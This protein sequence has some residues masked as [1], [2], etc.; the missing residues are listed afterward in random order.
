MYCSTE[1]FTISLFVPCRL[2]YLVVLLS[3]FDTF[4][5]SFINFDFPYSIVIALIALFNFGCWWWIFLAKFFF[6][7]DLGLASIDICRNHVYIIVA[8]L[9]SNFRCFF[10]LWA[11]II[12]F[13]FPKMI[14]C[15][16]CRLSLKI[17]QIQNHANFSVKLAII[18]LIYQIN[19]VGK[20]FINSPD[21]IASHFQYSSCFLAWIL[22]YQVDYWF[23]FAMQTD[24]I[25]YH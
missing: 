18:N 5:W 24:F 22:N 9:I 25:E 23:Q 16:S 4:L 14:C 15:F 2:I 7:L 21:S 17:L 12:T 11:S 13:L 1:L 19:Y 3:I 8:V 10:S 6:L 20:W